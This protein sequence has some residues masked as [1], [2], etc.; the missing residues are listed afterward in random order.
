MSFQSFFEWDGDA[1]QNK[2]APGYQSV[3]IV[4]HTDSHSIFS[5]YLHDKVARKLEGPR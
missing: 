3:N 1:A 4:S 5:V 2:R